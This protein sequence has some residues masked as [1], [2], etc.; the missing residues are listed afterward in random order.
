M[1]IS[2][3]EVK[4]Y[5][6]RYQM[7]NRRI[8]VIERATLCGV[9]SKFA[10][11]LIADKHGVLDCVEDLRGMECDCCP[12][13]WYATPDEDCGPDGCDLHDRETGYFRR[14]HDRIVRWLK[15]GYIKP[16]S[17]TIATERGNQP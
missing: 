9:Y 1:L 13:G 15:A 14:L 16:E 2:M 8:V 17:G 4:R 6:W 3:Q 7:R 11:V 10:W 12:Y 5:R